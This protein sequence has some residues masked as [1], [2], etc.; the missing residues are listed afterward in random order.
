MFLFA[1]LAIF[2][3]VKFGSG[4]QGIRVTTIVYSSLMLVGALV[5]FTNGA[6]GILPAIIG[7]AVGGTLLA[8]TVQSQAAAWF[9]RPKY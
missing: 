2:L 4:G 7:L 9:N 6:S 3:G 8:S 1:G 5:N